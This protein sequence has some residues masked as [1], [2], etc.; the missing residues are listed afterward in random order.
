M[1]SWRGFHGSFDVV[2][3]GKEVNELISSEYHVHF[4]FHHS[5]GYLPSKH[6]DA[7]ISDASYM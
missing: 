6:I 1:Q 5:A 4:A 3:G 2:I 7:L